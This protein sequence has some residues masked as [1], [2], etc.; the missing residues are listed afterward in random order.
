M[1]E[2]HHS[3]S[4]PDT[5]TTRRSLLRAAGA[6]LAV[7]GAGVATGVPTP[8][9]AAGTI[10]R[11]FSGTFWP[12]TAPD[13]HYVPVDVPKGVREIEVSYTYDRPEPNLPNG[14]AGN[15]LQRQ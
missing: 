3:L 8:G 10:T 14:T 4:T 12:G 11:S 2:N 6:G 1:C 5:G 15:T 7:V 9:A 13:W